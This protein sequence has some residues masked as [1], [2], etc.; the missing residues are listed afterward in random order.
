MLAENRLTQRFSKAASRYTENAAVQKLAGQLAIKQLPPQITGTCLDLGCGTGYFLSELSRRS[1]HT[2]AIDLSAPM[3]AH[4]MRINRA[5]TCLRADAHQLPLPNASVCHVFANF[6]L[7]WCQLPRVLA[8][9]YRILKPSGCLTF[10]LPLQGSL[11]EIAQ[12]WSNIDSYDHI[13]TFLTPQQITIFLQQSHFLIDTH[14]QKT[15]Q[16]WFEDVPALMQSIKK[17]G[18]NHIQNNPRPGLMTRRQWQKLISSFHQW[19]SPQ[20]LYPLTYELGVFNAYVKS[21][22]VYYRHRH[23]CR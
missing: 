18:A 19:I 9:I 2:V 17:I 22:L 3:L 4:A 21:D 11:R 7:Q 14:L 10:T 23:P 1:T 16:Q 15:T 13:N 6:S 5:I 8:E 20:G 12:A